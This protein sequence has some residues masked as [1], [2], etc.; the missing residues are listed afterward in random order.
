MR[1][2]TNKQNNWKTMKMKS[3]CKRNLNYVIPA[4]KNEEKKNIYYW[5]YSDESRDWS[6]SDFCCVYSF[7]WYVETKNKKKKTKKQKKSGKQDWRDI[8]WLKHNRMID[9]IVCLIGFEWATTTTMWTERWT[10]ETQK[11]Q[12]LY[13]FR[14]LEQGNKQ[15]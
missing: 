3:F 14:D 5:W 8:F 12:K 6:I 7:D 2:Q 11:T 1:V 4:R 10:I 13:I 9:L 15:T